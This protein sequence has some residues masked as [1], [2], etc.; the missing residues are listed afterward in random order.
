MFISA[1]AV[2]SASGQCQQYNNDLEKLK[3]KMS[4]QGL[5]IIDVSADGNCLFSSIAH[6]L[7]RP[8]Q[9]AVIREEIVQFI[10]INKKDLNEGDRISGAVGNIDAYLCK[11]R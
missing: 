10:E 11:M 6:Q 8:L 7:S 2:I 5:Q 4:R 1:G 3:Y 9:N